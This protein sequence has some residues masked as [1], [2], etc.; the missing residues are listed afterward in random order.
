MAFHLVEW[1]GRLL[2]WP[3]RISRLWVCDLTAPDT[4][5]FDG[6][7]A[8][9]L[10]F[11]GAA[12]VP[13]R[14]LPEASASALCSPG[15]LF[16]EIHVACF[17]PSFRSLA[18]TSLSVTPSLTTVPRTA[19]SPPVLPFHPRFYLLIVCPTP[20]ERK[21]LKQGICGLGVT[22]LLMAVSPALKAVPGT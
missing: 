10:A 3:A 12:S 13:H 14:L 7:A 19:D 18:H 17:L 1:R 2:Q 4:F 21:L 20:K 9:T 5:P 22:V 15:A 6:S 11:T 16:P 8:G